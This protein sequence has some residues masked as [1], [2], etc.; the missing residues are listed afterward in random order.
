VLH[1]FTGNEG[2]HPEGGLVFDA[3]G[4]LYGVAIDGGTDNNGTVFK[5]SPN[6]DGTWTE[7]TIH[8]FAGKSGGD[9]SHPG[10]RLIF[11]GAGN[12]YGT[13]GSGGTGTLNNGTVF[14]LTQNSDGT[15]TE[16]VLTSFLADSDPVNPTGGVIL[17]AA[18]NLYGT[19]G[20]GRFNDGA[21]FELSPNSD[22]TWTDTVLYSFDDFQADASAGPAGLVFDAAGDLYGAAFYCITGCHGTVYKLRHH[23]SD[24]NLW[25]PTVIHAFTA[26]RDGT[27][28]GN[29]IFDAAGNL[30]GTAQNGGGPCPPLSGPLAPPSICGKVFKLTPNSNGSW[31]ESVPHLFSTEAWVAGITFDAAG[32]L[33]GTTFDGGVNNYGRVF[34][35]TPQSGGGW[36][37]TVPRYFYGEPNETPNGPLVFDKG[38]D[39][40]GETV[41]CVVESNCN[42]AIFEITP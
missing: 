1:E 8:M 41:Q 27:G 20:G 19:S 6:S 36:A 18:G 12:L 16:T 15:W 35:L 23:P 30:Y 4:N 2:L 39:L 3:A 26:S 24:G 17:D 40:Y 38:G 29:L 10:G 11:D 33:Y 31:S 37:Y 13:T 34:E 22:G 42:G 32:N 9:G 25:T 28:P 5:L 21:V 7:T 14:K